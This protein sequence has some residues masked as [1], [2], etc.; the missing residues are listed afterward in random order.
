MQSSSIFRRR[1]LKRS[2][3]P[4]KE[5]YRFNFTEVP[6]QRATKEQLRM[7]YT[8]YAFARQHSEG[9]DVLEI[10]CGP[11]IGLSYISKKAKSLIAGDRDPF[12]LD[13]AR[14][15]VDKKSEIRLLE[16][17]AEETPFEKNSFDLLI[18]FEAIYFLNSAQR[19]LSEAHRLLRSEGNILVSTVNPDWPEFHPAKTATEYLN[20]DQMVESLERVGFKTTVFGAFP[21]QLNTLTSLIRRS[22]SALGLFPKTVRNKERLKRVFYG[23]LTPIPPYIPEGEIPIENLSPVSSRKEAHAYKILYILGKKA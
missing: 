4:N 20:Y 6:G 15:A 7:L 18:L 14:Y 1:R 3:E 22:A 19:F 9:K 13:L 17:D 11:G 5:A 21:F 12:V 10:G 16:F 8:R 23:S 2:F